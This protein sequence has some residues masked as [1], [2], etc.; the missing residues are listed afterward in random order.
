MYSP[1]LLYCCI[2]LVS[3]CVRCCSHVS[4]HFPIKRFLKTHNSIRKPPKGKD[5]GI[6]FIVIVAATNRKLA[7]RVPDG[8]PK[9]VF[10][11]TIRRGTR[12]GYVPPG[13][14]RLARIPGVRLLFTPFSISPQPPQ[15]LHYRHFG[16]PATRRRG[17]YG[18]CTA[19]TAAWRTRC[20]RAFRN[21]FGP[22]VGRVPGRR[23][24]MRFVA[25]WCR[26]TCKCR[27]TEASR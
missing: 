6:R 8:R 17:A 7:S 18:R 4:S 24:R 14:K 10:G 3:L 22:A 27:F 21:V 20:A 1:Y 9:Y 11:R 12:R 23:R 15:V 16:L 13:V 26:V 5:I 25:P 19:A 2:V